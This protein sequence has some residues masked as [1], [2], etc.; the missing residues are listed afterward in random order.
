MLLQGAHGGLA[1]LDGHLAQE[2]PLALS[3]YQMGAL[4]AYLKDKKLAI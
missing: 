3:L 2:P 1:F 4:V